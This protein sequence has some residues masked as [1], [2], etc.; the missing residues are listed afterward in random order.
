MFSDPPPKKPD[1]DNYTPGVIIHI[2]YT[3]LHKFHAHHFR[4]PLAGDFFF[5]AY[6]HEHIFLLS[7]FHA[8]VSSHFFHHTHTYTNT[9]TQSH[10]HTETCAHVHTRTH[11]KSHTHTLIRTRMNALNSKQ[12]TGRVP[13]PHDVHLHSTQISGVY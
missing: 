8:H 10:T 9:H 4:I 12:I 1:L 6:T 2:L 13:P 3:I 11:S 5:H 7:F